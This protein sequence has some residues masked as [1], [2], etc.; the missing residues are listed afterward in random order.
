LSDK[1]EEFNDFIEAYK[2]IPEGSADKTLDEM[3][4]N[5]QKY[6][7][8]E[9]NTTRNEIEYF[10]HLNYKNKTECFC[11]KSKTIYFYLINA[12]EAAE[13]FSRV[14]YVCDPFNK[15]RIYHTYTPR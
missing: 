2:R 11:D 14:V 1:E 4:T 12:Q 5:Y 13:F 3:N 6:K 10:T 15:Y 9:T 7:I 8:R